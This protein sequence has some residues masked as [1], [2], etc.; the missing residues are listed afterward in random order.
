[1]KINYNLAWMRWRWMTGGRVW[2]ETTKQYLRYHVIVCHPKL[3]LIGVTT[4]VRRQAIWRPRNRIFSFL[5]IECFIKHISLS[6]PCSR[7]DE[8]WLNCDWDSLSTWNWYLLISS[9]NLNNC[10]YDKSWILIT[11]D[12]IR[13]TDKL[14]NITN[15][16]IWT[17]WRVAPYRICMKCCED[18]ERYL[19]RR[20]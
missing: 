16:R 3:L 13:V 4:A 20:E 5:L 19:S 8:L 10:K 18:N 15:R 14:F 9:L 2:D 17:N 7:L 11:A 12:C 1:M 6:L